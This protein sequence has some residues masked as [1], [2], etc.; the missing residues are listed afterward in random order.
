M[1][2]LGQIRERAAHLGVLFSMVLKSAMGREAVRELARVEGLVL[3]GGGALHH[4][5]GSP[6]F[7]ADLDY[8]QPG[9]LDE[10]RLWY[11]LE[12][13]RSRMESAWGPCSLEKARGTDRL[14]RWKLRLLLRPGVSLVLAVECFPIPVHRPRIHPLLGA[15]ETLVPVESPAEIIADKMAASVDRWRTRGSLKLRDLYDIHLLLRRERCEEDLLRRKLADYG[16][17]AGKPLLQEIAAFLGPLLA[18]ELR[19]QLRGV[20]PQGELDRLDVDLVVAEVAA[21]FR[22]LSG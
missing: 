8:A 19:E 9:P 5:Y 15:E 3:Q 13:A 7:S 11:A 6:R 20:L 17:P 12:T 18:D 14:K 1:E 16:L 10:H 4:I 2:S 22:E 21:L